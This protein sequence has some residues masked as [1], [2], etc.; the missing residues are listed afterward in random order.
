LCSTPPPLTGYDLI[1]AVP[2]ANNNWLNNAV[3]ADGTRKVFE[4]CIIESGSGLL[5]VWLYK[6]D[7]DLHR[8]GRN[9]RSSRIF[10]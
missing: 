6:I 9:R 8:R 7:V 3:G 10:T 1:P 4:M 5:G 2:L